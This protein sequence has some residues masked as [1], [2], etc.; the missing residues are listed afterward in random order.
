MVAETGAPLQGYRWWML[1]TPFPNLSNR[2]DFENPQIT[3]SNDRLNWIMPEGITNPI[4]PAPANL[5]FW[6]SD[7]EL[8]WDAA[9]DRLIAYWRTNYIAEY[10]MAATSTD[11]ITWTIQDPAP[12]TYAT[13]GHPF[14]SPAI[15]QADDGS[16]RKLMYGSNYTDPGLWTAPDPLGPWT[17]LGLVTITGGNAAS[18]GKRHGDMIRYKGHW[19]AIY[20]DLSVIPNATRVMIAEDDTALTWRLS[21]AN[22]TPGQGSYRPTFIPSTEPEYLDVWYS[23]PSSNV[24]YTRIHESAWLDLLP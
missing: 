2:D 20:S 14:M 11:G 6:N 23:S 16:W 4:G 1:D 18:L 19:L 3:V 8:I 15:A 12:L 24:Y 10:L 5:S 17:N 9:E 22:V 21:S 7:C 13:N